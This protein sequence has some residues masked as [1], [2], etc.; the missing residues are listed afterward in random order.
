LAEFELAKEAR[1][2]ARQELAELKVLTAEMHKAI[3]SSG[4]GK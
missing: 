4:S 3:K 1:E 2:M